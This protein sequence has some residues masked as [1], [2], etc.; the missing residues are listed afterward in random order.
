MRFGGNRPWRIASQFKNTA[1]RPCGQRQLVV[2]FLNLPQTQCRG[3]GVDGIRK[4]LTERYDFGK[5]PACRGTVA[6]ELMGIAE[7]VRRGGADR[8]VVRAQILQGSPRLR[9]D[10]LG[11][12]PNDGQRRPYRGNTSDEVPRPVVRF[13]ALRQ[14][15]FSSLEF[16]FD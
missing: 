14:G 1:V 4:R 16:L 7:R 6:L 10:G 15:G 9:N 11:I 2:C 3:D 5:G 13:G 12:V 8:Q